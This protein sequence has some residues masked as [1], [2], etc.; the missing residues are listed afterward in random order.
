M[1]DGPVT[2][3]S[4]LAEPAMVGWTSATPNPAGRIVF[5]GEYCYRTFQQ[6]GSAMR[7]TQP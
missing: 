3:S 5:I 1:P 4:F 6:S 7:V 2:V